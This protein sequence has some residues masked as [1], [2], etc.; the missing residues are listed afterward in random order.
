MVKMLLTK[1]GV[2]LLAIATMG[3]AQT[4]ETD[5]AEQVDVIT[6]AEPCDNKKTI[7]TVTETSEVEQPAVEQPTQDETQALQEAQ[8]AVKE[9]QEAQTQA[10]HEALE[11]QFAAEANA[12]AAQE[13]AQQ[14]QE[15]NTWTCD[16]CGQ[17]IQSNIP[18]EVH[19][20]AMHAEQ[21]PEEETDGYYDWICE[22][23]GSTGVG[24][25]SEHVCPGQAK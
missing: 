13:A 19:D 8:E 5:P 4:V 23:C 9:A 21:E 2:A 11:A 18:K 22:K 3:T 17:Q 12:K 6:T 20:K 1:I 7:V 24:P 14:A 25:F 16:K 10:E 15:G